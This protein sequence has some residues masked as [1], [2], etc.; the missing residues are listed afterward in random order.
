M[1]YSSTPKPSF[2]ATSEP[3]FLESVVPKPFP[4]TEK[5]FCRFLDNQHSKSLGRWYHGLCNLSHL[6]LP[7]RGVSHNSW[8]NLGFSRRK[9]IFFYA[10]GL[11][12]GSAT[13]LAE[14]RFSSPFGGTAKDTKSGLT[15]GKFALFQ[16]ADTTSSCSS[17]W[18]NGCSSS[19]P[20]FRSPLRTAPPRKARL[21]C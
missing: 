16:P 17:K 5:S 1:L 12:G 19:L 8:R 7:S 2:T 15:T 11:S 14:L 6:Q 10:V 13:W 21:S 18:P 9:L 20:Y 4:P 3:G